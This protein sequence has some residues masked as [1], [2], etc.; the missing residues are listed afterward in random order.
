MYSD[1]NDVAG[2]EKAA[3]K[4]MQLLQTNKRMAKL[5]IRRLFV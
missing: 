5:C 2:V 1:F 4:V 3:V